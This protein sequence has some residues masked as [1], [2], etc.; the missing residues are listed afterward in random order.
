MK[1]RVLNML[2]ALDQFL[3]C[4]LTFGWSNPDETFSSCAWRLRKQGRIIGYILNAGINALF[5]D[6]NHCRKA[7]LAERMR[8]NICNCRN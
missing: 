3:F 7:Y 1:K 2:I 4:V 8:C 6:R 5:F